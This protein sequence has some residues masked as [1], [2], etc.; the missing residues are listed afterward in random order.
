MKWQIEYKGWNGGFEKAMVEAPTASDAL[1]IF[2]KNH[3]GCSPKVTAGGIVWLPEEQ[4]ESS[5]ERSVQLFVLL[6]VLKGAQRCTEGDERYAIMHVLD[7]GRR[8]LCFEH[9]A[10]YGD[11][12]PYLKHAALVRKFEALLGAFR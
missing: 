6:Q 3:E 9:A 7:G 10:G 5:L 12:Y 8:Y 11:A 2:N 4:E 1:V